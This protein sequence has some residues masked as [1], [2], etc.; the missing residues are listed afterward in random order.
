M[1]YISG[2][3][4]NRICVTDTS[5]GVTDK[6]LPLEVLQAEKM[7][8]KIIGLY[9]YNGKVNFVPYTENLIKLMQA[10]RGTPVSLKLSKGLGYRQMLYIGHKLKDCAVDSFYFFDDSGMDGYCKVTSKYIVDNDMNDCFNFEVCDTDRLRVLQQ[11]FKDF[12]G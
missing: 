2:I 7:G 10:Q 8:Y 9:H 5:D 6:M 11:R 4:K 12:G 1:Y 3:L